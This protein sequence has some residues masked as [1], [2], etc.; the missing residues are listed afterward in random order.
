MSVRSLR[1]KRENFINK[2][3]VCGMARSVALESGDEMVFITSLVARHI[4]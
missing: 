3:L 4:F 1:R 2:K